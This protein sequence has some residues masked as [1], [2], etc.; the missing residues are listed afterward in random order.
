MKSDLLPSILGKWL[1]ANAYSESIT[2]A[3]WCFVFTSLKNESEKTHEILE[4]EATMQEKGE[5]LTCI[6][7]FLSFIGL[8]LEQFL[9]TD[10]FWNTKKLPCKC[11]QQ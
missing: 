1:R 9:K 7:S 10:K 5:I 6:S 3:S 2:G 11:S 4:K 8:L